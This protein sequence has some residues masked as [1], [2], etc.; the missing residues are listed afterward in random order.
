M[1]RGTVGA[2]CSSGSRYLGAIG[3]LWEC[4]VNGGGKCSRISGVASTQR[5]VG[6]RNSNSRHERLSLPQY[7]ISLNRLLQKIDKARKL[8]S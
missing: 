6:R 3:A 7:K 4:S 2:G 8:R 5:A 1:S